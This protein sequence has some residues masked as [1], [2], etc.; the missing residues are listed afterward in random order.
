MRTLT[1]ADVCEVVGLT[2]KELRNLVEAGVVTPDEGG[3]GSGSH[4]RFS[5]A[6]TVAVRYAM[7]WKR[8][9][10]GT[11]FVREVFECLAAFDLAGLDAEIAVGRVFVLP[12]PGGMRLAKLKPADLAGIPESLHLY[13]VRRAVEYVVDKI[14]KRLRGVVGRRRGLAGIPKTT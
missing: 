13:F 10:A 5:L 3:S 11:E 12:I 14:E 7:G 2:V 6:R 8:A 1:M 9:G 4:R